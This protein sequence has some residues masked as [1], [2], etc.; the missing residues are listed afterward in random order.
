MPNDRPQP[1]PGKVYVEDE[2]ARL[3]E[4][5]DALQADLMGACDISGLTDDERDRC[6]AHLE[7]AFAKLDADFLTAC[8]KMRAGVR[9]TS[10]DN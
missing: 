4:A 7:A 10:P 6:R 1:P 5:F 9:P 8:E 2:I 3:S